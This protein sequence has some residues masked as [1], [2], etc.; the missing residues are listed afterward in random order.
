MQC[1][2]TFGWSYAEG[3]VRIYQTTRTTPQISRCQKFVVCW[4]FG[5]Q[6]RHCHHG[7]WVTPM[8]SNYECC[9]K[10]QPLH[11]FF[12]PLKRRFWP[13]PLKATCSQ[14][15][16]KLFSLPRFGYFRI[17]PFPRKK[18]M[19]TK[20][21]AK[22]TTKALLKHRLC[23][24][25]TS[26]CTRSGAFL[27]GRQHEGAASKCQVVGSIYF[28]PTWT[29]KTVSLSWQFWNWVSLSSKNKPLWTNV[30]VSEI[31]VKIHI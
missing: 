23:C 8:P 31:L 9:W 1:F 20:P 14:N 4:N 3:E 25:S 11:C 27:T 6:H 17:Y 28:P 13:K 30:I 7:M 24:T 10:S 29:V 19:S 18:K 22:S 16:P 21:T 2:D 12:V 15:F 26:Q 5:E